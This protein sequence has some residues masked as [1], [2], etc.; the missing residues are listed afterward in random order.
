MRYWGTAFFEKKYF[1]KNRQYK[2]QKSSE[3]HRSKI[4]LGF[5]KLD[6]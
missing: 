5:E 4:G 6:R 2:A 3:I 1:K